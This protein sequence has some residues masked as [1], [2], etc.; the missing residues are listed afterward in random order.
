VLTPEIFFGLPTKLKFEMISDDCTKP[1]RVERPER[2]A[3]NTTHYRS[4]NTVELLVDDA[5]GAK[6]D[7]T[8]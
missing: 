6:Y 2:V 8:D 3:G 5:Y 1:L 4:G 7:D